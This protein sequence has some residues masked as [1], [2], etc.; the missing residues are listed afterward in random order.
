MVML[1][2]TASKALRLTWHAIIAMIAVWWFLQ[3]VVVGEGFADGADGAA[4]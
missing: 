3:A 4:R 1:Q 2:A